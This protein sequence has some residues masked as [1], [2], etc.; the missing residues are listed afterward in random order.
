MLSR[1]Q[2]ELVRQPQQFLKLPELSDWSP[3]PLLAARL[4]E[5]TVATDELGNAC[6]VVEDLVKVFRMAGQ[7]TEVA[8]AVDDIFKDYIHLNQVVSQLVC[9]VGE[10]ACKLARETRGFTRFVNGQQTDWHFGEF[11]AP[12]ER[13]ES[14]TRKLEAKARELTR[15]WNDGLLL[16][17]FIHLGKERPLTTAEKI[18]LTDLSVIHTPVLKD[19]SDSRADWYD[20][21]GR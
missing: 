6:E 4:E 3:K 13:L 19:P 10:G 1:Q 11:A 5:L 17:L 2:L 20:E 21:D 18:L 9:R 8:R 15:E 16:E 7:D 12:T 14:R